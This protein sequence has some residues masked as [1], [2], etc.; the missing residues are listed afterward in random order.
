M[1]CRFCWILVC[2]KTRGT[3]PLLGATA[4]YAPRGQGRGETAAPWMD[5]HALGVT[6]LTLLSGRAP[7]ALLPADAS[8]W[9]CPPDLE[10]HEGFR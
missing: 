1:V 7:E 4:S 6:A 2:F 10:L 3:A 8:E 9:Q 5:L